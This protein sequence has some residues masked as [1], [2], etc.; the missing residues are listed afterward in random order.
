MQRSA[1]ILQQR[2]G[3]CKQYTNLYPQITS[4][5]SFIKKEIHSTCLS[6]FKDPH[7]ALVSNI[8]CTDRNLMVIAK[9]KC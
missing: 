8:E 3:G 9:H 5:K 4:F 1:E 2:N 7:N 6:D